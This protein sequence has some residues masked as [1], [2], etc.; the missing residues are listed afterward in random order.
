MR[1]VADRKGG[2]WDINKDIG[3]GM[4]TLSILPQ[5]LESRI[6]NI[7]LRKLDEDPKKQLRSFIARPITYLITRIT[8]SKL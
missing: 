4:L 8:L 2:K 7:S 5:G 1:G 6:M 3:D